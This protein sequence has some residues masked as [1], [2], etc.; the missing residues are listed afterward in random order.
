MAFLPGLLASAIPFLGR[1]ISGAV[2]GLAKG[3]ERGEGVGGVL[4]ETG[5]GALHGAIGQPDDERRVDPKPVKNAPEH[6]AKEPK[7]VK[8]KGRAKV[9]VPHMVKRKK[10]RR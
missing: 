5:L 8:H 4:K 1:T 7:V 10:G 3:I 9:K 6:K 2:S